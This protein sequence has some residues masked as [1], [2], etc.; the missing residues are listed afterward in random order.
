MFL[1]NGVEAGPVSGS[2]IPLN[3]CDTEAS[4]VRPWPPAFE[5]LR[6]LSR[7][8]QQ[9][10]AAYC[11]WTGPRAGWTRQH[12]VM[13][14]DSDQVVL[15]DDSPAGWR[16]GHRVALLVPGLGGSQKTPYL[17]RT[18][19]KLNRRGTRTF[20]M[21]QRGFGSA[22]KLSHWPH[23]AG[24]SEDVAAALR[25]IAEITD[26]SSASLVGFSLGGNIAL[27]LAGLAPDLVPSNLTSVMAVNPPIDLAALIARLEH[28]SNRFYHQ[29]FIRSVLRPLVRRHKRAWPAG[30]RP[31]RFRTSHEFNERFLAPVCGFGTAQ[32]YYELCSSAPVLSAI[33]LP[34]LVLTSRDDPLVPAD[35]FERARLSRSTRLVMIDH[36]GHLGYL[37]TADP[38]DPDS[39]WMD[40]RVVDW[41]TAPEQILA[42]ASHACPDG[43]AS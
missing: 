20:R 37:G 26:G 34:T 9:T 40:W 39:R 23:H 32:R 1:K 35:S 16:P 33:R 14:P 3:E 42:R 11:A 10:V 38:P 29:Y 18:A 15:H 27:K 36:G 7:G 31:P 21:D 17:V 41:V 2:A 12:A 43:V 8:H 24:R 22:A 6:R 25:S 30:A 13:L 28:P 19:A 4:R 5:P